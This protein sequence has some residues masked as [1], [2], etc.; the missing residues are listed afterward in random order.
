MV[1]TVL[2]RE[3]DTLEA[4]KQLVSAEPEVTH[5]SRC[6]EVDQFICL[7]CDGIFDVFINEDLARYINT[8]LVM[9]ENATDVASDI[10]DTSLHK[11]NIYCPFPKIMSQ[12][13]GLYKN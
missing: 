13:S 2:F 7:A 11:V 12:F 1:L 5:V 4:V 6:A 8:Q 10:I 3:D 9:R